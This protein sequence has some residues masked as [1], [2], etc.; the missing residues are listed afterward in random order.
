MVNV[1][2]VSWAKI[3]YQKF[4]C[5]VK[6]DH[7]SFNSFFIRFKSQL[8]MVQKMLDAI[9]TF[10]LFERKQLRLNEGIKWRT[11]RLNKEWAQ[12]MFQILLSYLNAIVTKN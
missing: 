12:R 7:V 3:A 2:A 11:K 1:F 5:G 8:Q 10:K 4:V 6:S 9:H